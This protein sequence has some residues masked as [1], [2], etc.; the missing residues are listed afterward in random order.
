MLEN[1]TVPVTLRVR[2]GEVVPIPTLPFPSIVSLS[3]VPSA[4]ELAIL[5]LPASEISMPIVQLYQEAKLVEVA[6]KPRS[7]SA[8]VVAL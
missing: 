5:N 3:L 4:V 2:Q 6:V 1:P 8:V 7:A